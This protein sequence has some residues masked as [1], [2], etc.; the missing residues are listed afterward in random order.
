MISEK[1]A[2]I[3]NK[4][5]DKY[6]DL[7]DFLDGKGLPVYTYSDFFENKGIPS[8]VVTIS[9]ILLLL[10]A[11]TVVLTYQ[12]PNVGQLT[13]SLKD[14][15]GKA[16]TG[17]SILI[18]D[19]Q[20]IEL[21][22]GTASDGQ[23]IA[24]GRALYNSDKI[25]ITAEKTG[26]QPT[27]LEFTIG[28][29]NNSPRIRFS[30]DFV[31]IEAKLR[32]V[33]KE[34]KTVINDATVIVSST[35]LSYEL[36]E[37]Q[38]GFYKK[39]GVPSGEELLLQVT[40]QGYNEYEQKISFLLGQV[41]EIQLEPSSQSYVGKS[42]VGI[43]VK[44]FDEKLIND[45]KVT[46]YNKQN[47]TIEVSDFTRNGSL[48]ASITA[49]VP[50]R[51][52]AEK[53]GYLSYDSDK[54]GEGVT[55]REKEKQ[56][57]ITLE[58]GGQNL[59]VSVNDSLLGLSLEG[60]LVQIFN[61]DLS[62]F[63]SEVTGVNG[64]DFSGLD[65]TETVYITAYLEGFLPGRQ[66]VY[67]S[68]TEEVKILLT[69]V[70]PTNSARLDIYSIDLQGNPVNGINVIVNEIVDGNVV[71]SGLGLLETS[72][73]GY[74]NAVV[75][76]EKTYQIVGYNDAFEAQSTVQLQLGDLDKKVYLNMQK[77]VNVIEMK[78]LDV[79]GKEILGNA[80]VNGLEGV[81][82]YD[83]NINLGSVFFDGEARET[84]EV[85]VELIDGNI[86]T[87]NVIIKGKNYVEVVVYN[88][89]SASL[90]PSVEFVGLENENG[91]IVEGITPGAF[92]WAKFSVT[93]P[94]AATKAGINFRAGSDNTP[95]A[96]SEKIGL[97]DLSM[98]GASVEYS[99]SYT[100]TPAPGNEAVDRANVGSQGE[101]NKWVEGT[102][103]Q[104][105]GTYTV[106]V[107]LRVEDFTPGKVQL[108][109][110]TWAI[111]GNEY[112]RSP[113]DDDLGTNGYTDDKSGLY[114]QTLTQDLTLY[115][116][117]PECIDTIC[118][119][120]N[121]VDSDETLLNSETF[122]ALKGKVY[123]LEVEVTSK[124]QD[125]LQVSVTSDTNVD[126]DSTQTGT[127]YFARE[128]ET[129]GSTKNNASIALSVG[130]EGKQKARF[131]FT[132]QEIGAA[133]IKVNVT[134]KSTIEKE[135]NFKVVN[136]K[137][138]LVELSE[139][140]VIVGRN[141]TVKVT[142]SGLVGM[143]NS[144]I[145]I[146]DREGKI[147][148]TIIGDNTDG[149][150]KSGYYRVQ[151]NLSVGVYTVEVSAPTYATNTT[152]ILIT[153]RNVFSFPDTI[154][155]KMPQGQKIVSLDQT[156][157]NNSDFVVQDITFEI[158]GQE[159][160]GEV[161][162]DV[163]TG[164][165]IIDGEFRV[166]AD[167]PP[168]LSKNQKQSVPI[169]VTFN[170]EDND[171]ADETVT[172][173][174]S[175]LV[176]GKFLAK[177]SS[178]IHM[179]YNRK[180]DPSC[181]K[182][183]ETSAVINLIGNEGSSDS[184]S[185]EV[186]N[187]C[188][189]AITLKKK[190][191]AKTKLSAVQLDA[192]DYL[193]L[194]AGEIKDLVITAYNRA[195]R[196][197]DEVYGFE[198]IY[199]S[200]YLKKTIN[201]TVKVMN[202]TLALSYPSQVTLYL[203][204]GAIK[205]KATAAQPLF[206][207]NISA[208]P[209]E[210]ISFSQSTSYSASNVKLEIQPAG[211]VSLERGQAITPPKVLFATA[212]SKITEPVES[213]IEITG[214]FGNMN[215]KA[216]QYDRYQYYD[217]Y[218]EGTQSLSTYSPNT[219]TKA[220]Y[221]NTNRVLGVIKVLA[222]YSGY[223]C[224]K[225][226]LADSM[227]DPYMFPGAGIQIG[228]MITVTNLCAEPVLLSGA[229]PADY[230]PQTT[231]FGMITPIA[232][233]V[234][235]FVPQVLVM[236]GAA[237]KVP[238]SITT[239]SP[240]VRREKYEIVV[241]GV[242][243]MSQTLIQSK[244]FGIK[245]Y[246]GATLSDEKSRST[247]IKVR[248]CVAPNSK[249][250]AKEVELIAPLITDSANCSDRYCDAQ[251]AA[252]YLAQKIEQVVQKARSAGYSKKDVTEDGFPCQLEGACT[253]SEIGMDEEELFDLY[254]QNDSISTN[255][256][257]KELNGLNSDGGNTTPFR[258]GAYISSGFLVE[259]TLVEMGYIKQRILSGYLKT[260]FF[261]TS[262]SGCGYYQ[263]S[264]SGAFKSNAEGLDTMSPVIVVRAKQINGA[265]KIVTKECQSEIG[266]ITN[267]NPVDL[268]LN[269]GKEYG[270]WLTTINPAT[271][272]TDMAAKISKDRFKTE[273]RVTASSNGN[274]ITITQGALSNALA[275]I[276]VTGSEKKNIIVTI[277]SSI[278]SNFDPKQKDAFS[279]SITQLVSN[280]LGGKFGD[281]CVIKTGEL[282][283]CINLSEL[284]N[285]GDRK[286]S[287]LSNDLMFS[288]SQGGC[289]SGTLY[290]T[291]NEQL[292]FTALP[293]DTLQTPFFGV[294]E[295]TV[296]TDDT[297]ARPTV[298]L[299]SIVPTNVQ[300]TNT[301]PA[302]AEPTH[303]QV[304][305]PN[306][307]DIPAPIN[308][309]ASTTSD[310]VATSENE[311]NT[312]KLFFAENT[313]PLTAEEIAKATAEFEKQT[314]SSGTIYT[315]KFNGASLAA[316]T[317]V[318][319]PIQLKSNPTSKQYKYY[320]NI[321]V[322][323]TPADKDSE[324][325][326]SSTEYTKANGVK[327]DLSIRNSLNNETT[328]DVKQ[329][330]T[331]N[332][333]TLHPDDLAKFICN[334]SFTGGEDYKYY[335]TT[336][337]NAAENEDVISKLGEYLEGLKR[338]G[339][340]DKCI[341]FT[342]ES[343]LS[344]TKAYDG[345]AEKA[346]SQ[347]VMGYLGAC[348]ATSAVCNGLTS[349]ATV[350]G[351]VVGALV[352]CGIP[353]VTTY[354][355]KL[356]ENSEAMKWIQDKF[357]AL[358]EATK[359]MPIIGSALSGMLLIKED[360]DAPD[361][362]V[363]IV[364]TASETVVDAFLTRLTIEGFSKMTSPWALSA[365]KTWTSKAINW[366]SQIGAKDPVTVDEIKFSKSPLS[367]RTF[368][369]QASGELVQ[370]YEKVLRE[371]TGVPTGTALNAD[372]TNLL[373]KLQ[374][375]LQNDIAEKMTA[376]A[377]K[378]YEKGGKVLSLSRNRVG[379]IPKDSYSKAVTE[380]IQGSDA[381]FVELITKTDPISG[382][383]SLQ[384]ILGITA[385]DPT[386]PLPLDELITKVQANPATKDFGDALA[387]KFV[388]SSSV[389]QVIK[390]GALLACT[391]G[392][393]KVGRSWVRTAI[394]V[395]ECTRHLNAIYKGDASKVAS[396]MS[397]L[398]VR[399]TS[400]TDVDLDKLRKGI[401]GSGSDLT[402]L[403]DDALPTPGTADDALKELAT[404]ANSKAAGNL[405]KA[406]EKLVVKATTGTA[407]KWASF[408]KSMGLGIG[409]SILSDYAGRKAMSATVDSKLDTLNQ[410]A[411]RAL[412]LNVPL[413]KNK[414]YALSILKKSGEWDYS[415]VEVESDEDRKEMDRT[416]AEKKGEIISTKKLIETKVLPSSEQLPEERKLSYWMIKTSVSTAK[417]L[418][419]QK[420]YPF[421]RTE[422]D[423]HLEILSDKDI[424]Q[425]IFDYTN[426]K[427]VSKIDGAKE[428]YVIAVMLYFWNADRANGIYAQIENEIKSNEG[429]LKEYTKK[430]VGA[431]ANH[432]SE[433]SGT[434]LT[435]REI[436]STFGKDVI[437]DKGA[438]KFLKMV[439]FWRI[440]AEESSDIA[441]TAV[442]SQKPLDTDLEETETISEAS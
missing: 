328:E 429:M 215:N 127:L 293:L 283:S 36:I 400:M 227:S 83:G 208:F 326:I 63:A 100:P 133:K 64:I 159:N 225:A 123:A 396:V 287:F 316:E 264:M 324:G 20:G 49:G 116:S 245:L 194:Q 4:A 421:E 106:K 61:S 329:T 345:P 405:K 153:T 279:Q 169:T 368:A 407:N 252:K 408:G 22:K 150:G 122:E 226:S 137:T 67:V 442:V 292:E 176:E 228:K 174:I 75:A 399:S 34:T 374:E 98:Q 35:D 365:Q 416:I 308:P 56:I 78:F 389:T 32:L 360:I 315:L 185:I 42:A 240:S 5:E 109:Y 173:T 145:K 224:L 43:S 222:M 27:S 220:S 112:Y 96:E 101:K 383:S 302:P 147:Q 411:K 338:Q 197:R 425:L 320:R 201:V 24:L 362:E 330:I 219:S 170:G 52:T 253:F 305:D 233:S 427:S 394:D 424:R 353:A 181:I 93:Y 114:A 241:N 12:G 439:E 370:P 373:K 66:R 160:D 213:M 31:S 70:T 409:C 346:Y 388:T 58:Q 80:I 182:I 349:G 231:T 417:V 204:Q 369:T 317:I 281:N 310:P 76:T 68:S 371:M 128:A 92:Y 1:L 192:E 382:Q 343:G 412:N 139:D 414:T 151:N 2:A 238:L 284:G 304:T 278:A 60:A 390:D 248:E 260:V 162:I 15:D 358:G 258:E 57:N 277:D 164:E 207:T 205:D 6:F 117:L 422:A 437:D 423:H 268:G 322:C 21:Y 99:T 110:R 155:V 23:K 198:I 88:K 319:S 37:D 289:I 41:K 149:K 307:T 249:E 132:A 211:S 393:S 124:E 391:E 386:K 377:D 81:T 435:N 129:T 430:L 375:T 206:V 420:N 381:K 85:N 178:E 89:D 285:L 212:N 288:S 339:I 431:Y 28:E 218:N 59:H 156:L 247:K 168:A 306:N 158:S 352:D 236:P 86:F 269:P 65:P 295:I 135:L 18:K 355:A 25:F 379:A 392:T 152:P 16:L 387:R 372:S 251:N 179:V 38:N 108:R 325:K 436:I 47:D 235:L 229:A 232:S 84:V 356:G 53:E 46:V 104:P 250:E 244:P 146:I 39:T 270:S 72:F 440:A 45:V 361:A 118:I 410:G 55:I 266:N 14:A 44:G 419:A 148:K 183:D 161:E 342:N 142:D 71:P 131:Y 239:A 54:S 136:E 203:A 321:K 378:A 434:K 254:L 364:Y 82:L 314:I 438:T 367:I 267:F 384:K 69:K 265:N 344:G 221:T 97:Y 195:E 262:F 13:L 77:K 351:S 79:F 11:M 154:E 209:I 257:Y 202:P 359:N 102:I 90:T 271:K 115:E 103:L 180:L 297:V 415:V 294:R 111:V 333:G 347:G 121:F 263:V 190:I 184:L 300:N 134:G 30:K 275:Q 193:D 94:R 318:N 119:T 366:T 406:N 273:D 113:I 433:K 157:S 327:F 17:V 418:L 8:F 125:Y 385:T 290:S 336:G 191:R 363:G 402:K 188:D 311:N 217:M 403:I 341:L 175:G 280:T 130:Q 380:A 303:T 286:L 95:L 398:K 334:T 242:T 166:E 33:D 291:I 171:S 107:K 105:K 299:D 29:N 309:L 357:N 91:D 186:T 7:L 426:D 163:E 246:S 413:Q 354:R 138:L 196:V 3:Y 255:M 335:F 9:I 199:D 167:I 51:I 120:T 301:N 441:K 50:L 340:V 234:L 237:V 337:W 74:V 350:L 401:A 397:E 48:V 404:L 143:T 189:Q 62:L 126:F 87:E 259:P 261:D 282:Y 223:N 141:F 230:K 296:S 210:N 395:A 165:E 144:L 256:L 348:G 26:Y 323:A 274:I 432:D 428:S 243:Q 73:A 187:N 172:M 200:N 214:R 10:I 376:S 216:A 272:F 313:A 177:I 332:T 40:A 312:E 298:Q 140:Q 331:I 276:C 19:K